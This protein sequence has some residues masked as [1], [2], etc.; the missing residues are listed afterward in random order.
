MHL[1][2]SKGGKG[3]GIMPDEIG[4]MR[5]GGLISA[6][7]EVAFRSSGSVL[8]RLSHCKKGGCAKRQKYVLKLKH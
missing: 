3:H 4:K 5:R 6:G 2:G 8:C 7:L 1:V